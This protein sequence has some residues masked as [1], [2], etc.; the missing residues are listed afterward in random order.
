MDGNVGAMQKIDHHTVEALELRAPGASTFD[1]EG[2]QSKLAVGKIFGAFNDH[3]RMQIFHRL[4]QYDSLVPSLNTFFRNLPYW[5]ACVESLRQLTTVSRRDT[6]LTAF[7]R[8]FTAVNQQDGQ[9]VVQVDESSFTVT[10]GSYDDQIE[11]GYRHIV[12]SAMRHFVEIPR[13]PVKKDITV[14]PRLKADQAVL[15]RFAG[16][17]I[18]LG[19]ESP[20]IHEL[21]R[22][23]D[24]LESPVRPAS[25]KPLLVTSGSGEPLQRRC[26]L[27][28]LDTFQANRDFLFLP[29][30]HDD[31][32]EHGEGIT[33]FFVLKAIY[34]AFMG[35]PEAKITLF[36][37]QEREHR[38]REQQ[39]QRER[40][41][42]E[43]REREQQ[44]QR[45]REQAQREKAHREHQEQQER[46]QEAKLK[47]AQLEQQ[48]REKQ[49]Q[50]QREQQQ[51]EQQQREQQQREQ[52]QRE[53]QQREQQQR[54]QQQREQQQ[55]EQQQREQQQREQQQRE[56][57]EREQQQREREEQLQREQQEREQ[58]ERE[59]QEREQQE[60]EQQEREQQ[61]RE[62]QEREQQEREQQEREQQERE[63]QEREQQ[64]REQQEREKQQQEQKLEQEAR[65]AHGEVCIHFKIR[66]NNV[67]RDVQTLWVSRSDPSEVTRVAK[68]CMRKGLRTLDTNGQLVAP[69][70]IFDAV[71][72]DETNTIILMP[73]RE[74]DIDDQTLESANV[75]G[76]EAIVENVRQKRQAR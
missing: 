52:Q 34:L 8:Q 59:Q 9:V 40:E 17:A 72:A 22:N 61:E 58:Q 16:L 1:A 7:E 47:Q 76:Y 64:E 71:M 38:Q 20:E 65:Q 10:P 39:E 56:Q 66:E 67:W 29:Y 2:I 63:Q 68:K 54:E 30:L 4:C 18:R 13:E 19:F 11:L 24:D 44:E 26:G 14:R 74:L 35:P 3:D 48:E 37:I 31:Q 21:L 6:V 12:A 23:G 15:R 75:L 70:D 25:T 28:I 49:E 69:N 73:Q 46:E 60:R 33:S 55:R 45:E 57:Q 5:E 50:Q 41:Q 36:P 51:R 53:Q 32:V 42:Q 62:Q 43:Q 27:P